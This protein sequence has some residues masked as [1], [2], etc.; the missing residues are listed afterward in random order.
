[1]SNRAIWLVLRDL[2]Y[3]AVLYGAAG[4]EVFAGYA[5]RYFVPYVQSAILQGDFTNAT[6]MIFGLSERSLSAVDL[7]K[8]LMIVLPGAQRAFHWTTTS[9]SS[10]ESLYQST[11]GRSRY[12]MPWGFDD[13]M[14]A[15]MGDMQLNYWLRI[16][17]QNS[18][19]VPVELRA[20]FLDHKVVET[21]FSLPA[22]YLVRDGWMKW[23][24]RRA[25][26]KTLPREV[27]WRR[28]KMGF[29][30]PLNH[31]LEENREWALSVL[32]QSGAP[33]LQVNN[34][35]H[36]YDTTVRRAPSQ[37]WRVLSYAIWWNAM[38]GAQRDFDVAP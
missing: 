36:R 22:S 2:G 10:Q 7:H 6:S 5:N 30:F 32:V 28:R 3:R 11:P 37:A 34:I 17:N 21:A 20:P 35:A 19:A 38:N 24:L 33:N 23:I 16:D 18:M 15:L 4:D 1:M 31:W 12:R 26:E 27:V 14:K 29:P 8:R 9:V 13:R 25:F